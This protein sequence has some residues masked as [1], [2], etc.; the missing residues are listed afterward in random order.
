MGNVQRRCRFGQGCLDGTLIRRN[1]IIRIKR[2]HV[3]KQ[4]RLWLTQ[5]SYWSI[6]NTLKT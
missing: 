3:D 2:Y 5:K 4:N 1:F 6:L